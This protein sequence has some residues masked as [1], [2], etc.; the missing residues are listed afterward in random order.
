MT[1]EPEVTEE[2]AVTCLVAVVMPGSGFLLLT[3]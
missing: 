3:A 1:V 2:K